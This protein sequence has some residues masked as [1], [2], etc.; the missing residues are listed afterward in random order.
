[1]QLFPIIAG[2]ALVGGVIISSIVAAVRRGGSVWRELLRSIDVCVGGIFTLLYYVYFVVT[3]RS[4]EVF[5]TRLSRVCC[6]WLVVGTYFSAQYRATVCTERTDGVYTLDADPSLSC[7]DAGSSQMAL[8]PWAAASL[9]IYGFVAAALSRSAAADSLVLRLRRRLGVPFMFAVVLLRNASA[10][11][12]D[13]QLWIVGRGS[14]TNDN[15]NFSM[16]ICFAKLYQVSRCLPA[17]ARAK[18]PAGH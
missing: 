18:L 6:V 3:K 10:I 5:G 7:W 4:L 13:Q 9:I 1:M 17:D 14:T 12:C 11:R 8:I 16:R 2:V 15:P